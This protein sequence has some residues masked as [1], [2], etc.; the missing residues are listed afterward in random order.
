MPGDARANTWVR[1]T[2]Q[3]RNTLYGT[4]PARVCQTTRLQ[5]LAERV[6]HIS[7]ESPRDEIGSVLDSGGSVCADADG[8]QP[9]CAQQLRTPQGR[10]C[11]RGG[12]R[13]VDSGAGPTRQRRG[14]NLAL[15]SSQARLGGRRVVGRGHVVLGESRG[16]P[17]GP[18]HPFTGPLRGDLLRGSLL[19]GRGNGAVRSPSAMA[20]HRGRAGQRARVRAGHV[21]AAGAQPHCGQGD[22]LGPGRVHA[23]QPHTAG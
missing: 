2:A 1:P 8:V 17:A 10:A 23:R 6:E 21:R 12:G 18:Q 22:V 20:P 5:I 16:E 7:H 3:L 11:G 13:G 19:V 15:P 4:D 14:R 9:L